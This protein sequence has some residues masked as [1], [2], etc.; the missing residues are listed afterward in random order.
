MK[1]IEVTKQAAFVDNDVWVYEIDGTKVNDIVAA[2]KIGMH[3]Y[4]VK[5]Q[6]LLGDIYIRNLNTNGEE[7]M[8]PPIVIKA[9]KKLYAGVCEA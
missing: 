7:D 3:S 9:N 6:E 8:T 1:H 4:D 5:P 2:V